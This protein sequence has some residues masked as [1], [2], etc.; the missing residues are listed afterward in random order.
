MFLKN[1]IRVAITGR[2][3]ARHDDV[4]FAKLK[5]LSDCRLALVMTAS[6]AD[7]QGKRQLWSGPVDPAPA[8]LHTANLAWDKESTHTDDR[9]S[10]LPIEVASNLA[11]GG[12][13]AG[14]TPR[15][16]GVPMQEKIVRQAVDLLAGAPGSRTTV[17][18][19]FAWKAGDPAWRSRYGRVDPAER[20]R[21]LALGEER[22]RQKA[23]ARTAKEG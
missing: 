9:G 11:R 14:R 17:R 8:T 5:P 6:P 15:F 10:F 12:V 3:R 18:S 1:G 16:H 2:K 7:H 23:G 19:P 4:P 13:S 21:L 20:E 22:R